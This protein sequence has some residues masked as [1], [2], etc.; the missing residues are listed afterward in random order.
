MR[1]EKPLGQ[2]QDARGRLVTLFNQGTWPEANYIETQPN[3]VRG[4]HYHQ[5]THEMVFMIEGEVDVYLRRLDT[6]EQT[7]VVLRPGDI[8]YIEP[9]E[10][11]AFETRTYCRWLNFLS[12]PFNQA[13]PDIISSPAHRG[14]S[15]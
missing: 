15:S 12:Q 14:S 10:V 6:G 13:A 9:F 7:H 3:V 8:F 4:N 1:V 2:H 11:H 5:S